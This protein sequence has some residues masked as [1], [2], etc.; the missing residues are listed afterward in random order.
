MVTMTTLLVP[1][2]SIVEHHLG[3]SAGT[4]QLKIMYR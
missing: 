3:E 4:L 2:T 1:V